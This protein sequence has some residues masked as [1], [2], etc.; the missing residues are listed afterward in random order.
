MEKNINVQQIDTYSPYLLETLNRFIKE[1]N[2]QLLQLT[3]NY[4]KGLLVAPSVKLF[5]AL[6]GEEI[7]GTITLI[8]SPALSGK[9]GWI[10]DVFVDDN[11][12]SKGVGTLLVK[13]LLEMAKKEGIHHIDLTSNPTRVAANRLYESLGFEKRDTNDY[14]IYLGGNT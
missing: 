13:K 10:Q 8:M 11:H 14:R 1:L 7:I 5:V 4:L 6:E 9:R 3:E 12:R 2:P